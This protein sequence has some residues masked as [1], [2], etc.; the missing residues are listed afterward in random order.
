MQ[1][2]FDPIRPARIDWQGATPVARDCG[3][4]Y[5]SREDGP[6]EA[7]AVFIEGNHL[8]RRFSELSPGE[9]FVI[10]ETGFGTGLNMLLATDLFTRTAPR[11]ARLSLLSAERCPLAF[12]DLERALGM[13]PALAG[14]AIGLRE[15]YPPLTPGFHRLRLGDNVDLTLMFGDAEQMWRNQPARVDAWF[16]DGFAPTC[17]PSMWHFE[18]LALLARRSRPG[19]TLATFSAAGDV[20]RGLAKAGFEIQRRPGFGRK[21][22][23][24]EGQMA[25][26]WRPGRIRTGE[27]AIFGAGLAGATTARALAERGWRVRVIDPAGIARGASGNHAGVVYTTP[28]GIATPQNRFYQAS[29]LHA[30][31]WCR[32]YRAE[33]AG[34]GTFNGV[35]QHI[36]HRRQR[37]KLRQAATSGHWPDAQMRFVDDDAVLL[38]D[39]GY[40]Q[41]AKWCARLLD[42]TGIRMETGRV[43]HIDALARPVLDTG[44]TCSSDA[45][46]LCLAGGA[47]NLPGLPGLALREIRGQVTE[48]RATAASRRWLQAQCHAG[49]LT[50]AMNG[51]HCVGATF[52]LD[53]VATAPRAADDAA[54]LEQLARY[55]PRLWRELGGEGIEIVS[56]RVGFR[57]QARDYL[58]LAGRVPG[59]I[60]AGA[61][62]LMLNLAHGSRGISGTPLIADL[63]AD[64][65]SDLPAAVDRA[66]QHALDPA[67]FERRARSRG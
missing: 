47:R 2:D 13:W 17:N 31:G 54:N 7:L 9:L 55:L 50:P 44:E 34:I 21:R 5:F 42:H 52:D 28:S 10:G 32:T 53:D 64:R 59:S 27:A 39:G 12:A 37:A 46:V 56:Q 18:L 16:L 3:D 38:V 63:I 48:C 20:R 45:S 49:Y 22:H 33:P 4:G 19:A 41:P 14:P 25:G 11:G 6:A 40:L 62:P 67:R 65:L 43:R 51:L 60:N 24:L 35:V 29:Y 30:A 57:C 23:R 66:M 8:T 36:T 58:P 1:P 15:Q 26:R 61:A